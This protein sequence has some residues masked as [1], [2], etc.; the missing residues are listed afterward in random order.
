MD[1][2]IIKWNVFK[3]ILMSS[4]SFHL[5]AM[6]GE[7][8]HCLL[9]LYLSERRGGDLKFQNINVQN[10]SDFSALGQVTLTSCPGL[11]TLSKEHNEHS[12]PW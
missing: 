2:Y 7:I 8:V 5:L 3:E 6:K 9:L 12:W 1:T 11:F 4:K 10:R